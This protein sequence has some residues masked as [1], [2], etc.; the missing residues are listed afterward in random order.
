M[1]RLIPVISVIMIILLCGA[2]FAKSKKQLEKKAVIIEITVHSM[3]EGKKISFSPKILTREGSSAKITVGGGKTKLN[4]KDVKSDKKLKEASKKF[5]NEIKITPEI[6]K[7][8]DPPRIKLDVEFLLQ[9]N[10][11]KVTRNFIMTLIEGEKFVFETED[12]DKKEKTKLIIIAKIYRD[13]LPKGEA[14]TEIKVKVK[15]DD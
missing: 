2:S 14:K 12:L 1:K 5:L 9:H 7:N 13:K 4:G 3:I 6:I 10:K 8:T 15:K 11:S